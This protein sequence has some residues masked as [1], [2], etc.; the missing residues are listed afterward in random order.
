MTNPNVAR[1]SI[2]TLINP[3]PNCIVEP[4]EVLVDDLNPSLYEP[5]LYKDFVLH[6]RG[7]GAFTKSIQG[8]IKSET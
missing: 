3:S 2:A 6:S 1:R 4:A 8:Y 5:T 7:F